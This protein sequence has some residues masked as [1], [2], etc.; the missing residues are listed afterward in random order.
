MNFLK[1]ILYKIRFTEPSNRSSNHQ[2]NGLIDKQTLFRQF[3]YGSIIILTV[4][5]GIGFII[6]PQNYLHWLFVI[7][8][9]NLGSFLLLWLNNRGYTRTASLIYISFLFLLIILLSAFNGGMRSPAI[10]ALPLVAIVAGLLLGWRYGLAAGILCIIGSFLVVTAGESGLIPISGLPFTNLNYWINSAMIIA[11]L[12]LLQYLSVNNMDKAL[13]KAQMELEIRL[14][15]EEKLKQSELFR[16]RIFESSSIPIVILNSET[17]EILDCNQATVQIF[18]ANSIDHVIHSNL[19]E[20]SA[21]KQNDGK[22]S[23]ESIKRYTNKAMKEGSVVFDWTSKQRNG[24]QWEAEVHLMRF[25]VDQQI[26]FQVTLEDIT[27]RKKAENDLHESEARYRELFEAEPDT[28]LLVDNES[29]KIM[30]ANGSAS[31]LYGYNQQEWLSMTNTDMSMEP[32]DTI[33]VRM[34]MLNKTTVFTIPLR[35]HRKKDGTIFPVE[36]TGR[37]FFMEGKSVHVAAI[38]DITERIRIENTL[39]ENTMRYKT[40]VENTP[41]IIARFDT[42]L[43]Y[44]FINSAIRKISLLNPEEII[45]KSMVEIGLSPEQAEIRESMIRKIFETE[46]PYESELEFVG[47]NGSNIFE[48]RGY[49]EFDSNGKVQSVLVFNRNISERKQAELQLKKNQMRLRILID[50]I[51]DL[52]WLKD[53]D[54]KYMQC[55]HRFESLFGLTEEE[56]LGKTDFDLVDHDQ[57]EFFRHYDLLAIQSGKHTVNE[58]TVSFLDG[59]QEILETIKAPIF[60]ID[61][62]PIGV[63]G[64][65]RNITERKKAE[66]ELLH[67]SHLNQ[68]I[69][70]STPAYM[71]AIK[72]EG[73][74]IMMNPSMQNALGY[75][76]EEIIGQSFVNLLV[77]EK[78]RE[79]VSQLFYQSIHDQ[80][81]IIMEFNVLSKTEQAYEIDWHVNF[82]KSSKDINY[83]IGIGID[84]TERRRITKAIAES[85]KKYSSLINTANEGILILDENRNITYLNNLAIELLGYSKEDLMGKSFDILALPSQQAFHQGMFQQSNENTGS[86]YEKHLIKKDGNIAWFILSLSPVIGP[87][88]EFQGSFVMLSD[89]TERKQFEV[90]LAESQIKLS[91]I[92]ESTSELIWSVDAE[93]FKIITYNHAFE[94]YIRSVFGIN[95]RLG[96]DI[97]NLMPENHQFSWKSLYIRALNEDNVQVIYETEARNLAF[98]LSLSTL[99]RKDK[100]FG[101]SIFAKDISELKAAEHALKDSEE[102]LKKLVN[103]VTD[104]IYKVQIENGH[105]VATDHGDGCLPVTG[106]ASYE[107]EQDNYLW[108]KIVHDLDKNAVNEQALKLIQNEVAKP[109]EHRIIHKNGSVRWVRNTP[110]LHYNHEGIVDSYNGLISDITERKDVEEKLK[111]NENLLGRIIESNPNIIYIYEIPGFNMVFSNRNIWSGLGYQDTEQENSKKILQNYIHPGDLSIVN[112]AHEQ[113]I[114]GKELVEFEYRIQA[115][116]GQWN[117]LR[118]KELIFNQQSDNSI[119]QILGTTTNITGQKETERRILNATIEAEERERNHFANELHDGL[120]PLLSSI[121]LYFEWLNKPDLQTPKEKISSNIE[122]TIQEAIVSVKEISHKLSPHM[123]TNFGLVFAVRAFID[124]LEETSA[125]HIDFQTNIEERLNREIEITLYRL[126][127]ECINNTIKHASATNITIKVLK[128]SNQINIYYMDD[129]IGFDYEQVMVSGKGLGLFNMQNRIATLG[130]KFSIQ[131]E[132]SHGVQIMA[133]LSV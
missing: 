59:H 116:D 93:D 34:N 32:E 112:A 20:Y 35:Y 1:F 76:E 66:E 75:S 45:G 22:L 69:I 33:R 49:P 53:L 92:L 101:I 67:E 43:R 68:T 123:L 82:I 25:E 95:V 58:E 81:S 98:H 77:P 8:T 26:L 46:Q 9:F 62:I 132:L 4:T 52:I 105:V 39:K 21:Y 41:D 131:T 106:Y 13:Q 56:L 119:L 27:Q 133:S 19:L 51:P 102:R 44:L 124:K 55:N 2:S 126:I 107:F 80:K 3:V 6:L 57:A 31:N 23:A 64:I 100:V 83:I 71:F 54:G 24:H 85:E 40:L 99:K 28:L 130:G 18:K 91:A 74:I 128:E 104:Y 36:I 84:L 79:N 17:L 11:L 12:T 117:W 86:R 63:I 14:Q 72:P 110:V 90:E 15:V 111:H 16:T 94:S 37:S 115:A 88:G 121:K 103:S 60:G 113:L 7:L 97:E 87:N 114:H 89:I 118:S 78:E 10:Q 61:G 70:E 129:G 127:I 38:R 122:A 42:S 30:Q 108:Y 109:L 50:T 5:I 120:G 73:E 96:I 65:G 29:G 47:L 48:W 125:L